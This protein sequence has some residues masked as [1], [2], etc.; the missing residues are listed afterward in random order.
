MD[1]EQSVAIALDRRADYRAAL[2]SRNAEVCRVDA[3]RSG[4]WPT[5]ALQGSYGGR[6]GVG[7]TSGPS[8][9]DDF[10]DLGR[11]GI[12][13]D[14]PLFRGGSVEARVRKATAVL[15][16]AEEKLRKIRLKVGLDVETAVLNTRSSLQR[17]KTA[18]GVIEQARES[19]RIEREKYDLGRGSI[20]DVLDAQ[21]ALLDAQT[22]QAKA[23][24]E[25][26][27]AM[28]QL[29]LAKGED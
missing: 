21:S 22:R 15:R 5:I 19:L 27:T 18:S 12:V 6:W 20:I 29:R 26:N 13:I 17:V 14:L 25:N 7:S 10:E 23:L 11:V 9:A 4:H 16:S 8:G 2:A 28:A 24:A 3:V 1:L